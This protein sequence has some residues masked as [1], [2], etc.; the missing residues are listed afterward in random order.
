MGDE[1]RERLTMTALR[2]FSEKGYESTS[3]SDILKAAGANSGSLYHFF[4]TKQDLLL[5]VLRRYR[6]GIEP[7]LLAP[8]WAG[9]DDPIER[10]FALLSAYRRALAGTECLYGCPIGS[11]ALEIHEP[12]PPVRELLATN[13][14]GWVDAIERCYVDAGVRLPRDIDRRALA[15]FTLTTMEGGVMQ[16]RTQR[17]LQAFDQSV[18]MLRDYVARLEQE[19]SKGRA[20]T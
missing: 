4:P 5:E 17:N 6:D 19:T 2:L 8:A 18:A 10:V 16:S 12:D 13:F 15:V 7:M 1:T 3:V 14:D 11:L 9:V 20:K